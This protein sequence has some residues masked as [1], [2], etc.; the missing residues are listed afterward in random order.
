VTGKTGIT[1]GIRRFSW[2]L[3]GRIAAHIDPTDFSALHMH[4]PIGI[5]IGL[6]CKIVQGS[7]KNGTRLM[8]FFCRCCFSK[9]A[10]R[11]HGFRF[12]IPILDQ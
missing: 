6:F 2:L 8:Y 3:G 12:V 4:Y 7:Q 11:C 1:P 9:L 10:S 5:K